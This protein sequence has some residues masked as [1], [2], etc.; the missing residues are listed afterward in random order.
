M[1]CVREMPVL[2]TTNSEVIDIQNVV[3]SCDLGSNIDLEA[4]AEDL[5]QS[6]YNA[7][8]FPGL[9]FRSQEPKATILIFR[10]GKVVCT[11][12][13]SVDATGDAFEILTNEFDKI[14]LVYDEPVITVQNIVA[15]SDLG[16]KLNLNA[17]AI[18][19]G[20]ENTEYE[21]EQFP[22]LIYRSENMETV[23]LLFGSGKMVVTGGTTH[24]AI[25]AAT[26]NIREELENLS[27]I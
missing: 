3:T 5:P 8:Q 10:S 1:N 4:L 7:S 25:I 6:Q 27:L 20:L 24:E 23:T 14:G 17:I 21:P 11:G 2:E 18:G 16:E 19:L 26:E 13:E 15:S 22:G 9:I 12:A